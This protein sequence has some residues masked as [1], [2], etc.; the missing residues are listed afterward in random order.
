MMLRCDGVKLRVFTI[1]VG[2]ERFS[3]EKYGQLV[4]GQEC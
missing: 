4:R 2:D 1:F 3:G